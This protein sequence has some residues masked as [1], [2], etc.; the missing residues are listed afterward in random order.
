[1]SEQLAAADEEYASWLA[2]CDEALASGE[3]ST[4]L[5]G[6]G[7]PAELRRRLESD[8]RCLRW[9]HRM[10][11]SNSGDG[12]PAAVRSATLAEGE[13]GRFHIR[14]ALGAGAYGEVFLAYD[15]HLCREVALKCRG[16]RCF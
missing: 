6:V 1:M 15:P 4:L 8:V 5:D 2:A 16:R 14:R 10:F 7:V 13:F 12:P 9:L 11:P 3:Q